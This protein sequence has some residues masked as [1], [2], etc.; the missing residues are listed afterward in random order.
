[1]SAADLCF[2]EA[3]HDRSIHRSSDERAGLVSAADRSAGD[4]YIADSAVFHEGEQSG[5]L[6]VIR[7]P[8]T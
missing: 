3:V 7:D 5:V 8:Q 2:G 1:M 6:T 4:A